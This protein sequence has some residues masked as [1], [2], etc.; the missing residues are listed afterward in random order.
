MR[1]ASAIILLVLT[2]TPLLIG[3]WD[4]IDIETRAYI[5]GIA[6]DKYPPNPSQAEKN[7]SESW[8]FLRKKKNLKR[9][10]SMRESPGMQ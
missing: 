8:I 6:I 5:L 4:R 10:N 2:V 7:D 9:W 1:R 3:C